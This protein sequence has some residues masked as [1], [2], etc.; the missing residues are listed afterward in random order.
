MKKLVLLSLF[1][2]LLAALSSM[3]ISSSEA[4]SIAANWVNQ[5][6][7]S[8]T[9]AGIEAVNNPEQ[10]DVTDWYVI[11]FTQG[12]FILI[13][14]DDRIQPVLGYNTTGSFRMVG[15]PD[16]LVW[17]TKSYHEQIAVIKAS[18]NAVSHPGWQLVRNG[19][20][21]DFL[22][23][24]AVSP[25]LQTNWDQGWP[26]NSLCPSASQGPGGHVYA[27]CG[28]TTMGQIMKYW[29]YPAH[30]VGSHTYTHPTYG[31]L[32]ANFGTATYNYS[33]MP[34]QLNWSAN[35][36]IST[37][38]YH[39]GIALDMDYGVDGSGA[40]VSDVRPAFVNYFSF[41]T[42][43]QTVYKSGYPA[44]AWDTLLKS[45]LDNS[46]PIFYFGTD[47]N[48]GVGHA[49]VCDGYQ[50]TNYFH[51]NW[52]WSGSDN[53][54]FYFSDLNPGSYHFNAQ[55]GAV[56]GLRPTAPVTAPTN[57]TSLV[58]PGDN[59]YLEWQSPLTRALLGF[60]VYRNGLVYDSITD[61]ANTYYFDINL[62]PGTYQYYIVANFSQ[63]D[64]QPSNTTIATIYPQAIINYQ[65][66][67]ETYNNFT[68]SLSPWF[69]Y[70]LDLSPTVQLENINYPT[71]GEAQ[72]FI[73]FNP[74][75]TTPPTTNFTAQSGQKVLA[76][77]GAVTAPNNDWIVSP[78]W[79]TAS[80]GRMKFWA[81]SAYPD[82]YLELI[83]V[84]IN[85]DSPNPSGMTIVSGQTPIS[86]PGTWTEYDF[87][88]TN[89]LYSNVFVGIQCVSNNGKMLLLDRLQLWSSYVDNE[90]II[91]V[92]SPG[93]VLTANPN[94]F[95][96][97][98]SV[99]WQ[100]KEA[101][102]VKVKV[103]D[104]KGQLVRTLLE[105][106]MPKGKNSFEWN[107]KDNKGNRVANG[108]YFL[109]LKDDAGHSA[110]SKLVK[111]N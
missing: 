71:E 20:F 80:V 94:P 5:I 6:S 41:E 108:M 62:T 57:L 100:Q 14:A 70:D 96:S 49:F 19:Y 81:K 24:R 52:G 54:Y 35:T 107:G 90:D 30:G 25:L 109:N 110:T 7:N 61:P 67:F 1:C 37:L 2:L 56:I 69:T 92:S 79:N 43:A 86:V 46:R 106:Q 48:I 75:A 44:T 26:Y 32:S 65:D 74:A 93:I 8:N 36:A 88:F 16:N 84:G 87:T 85:P 68:T 11:N 83:K 95:S 10:I 38:L 22:P 104:I 76:C 105:G 101:S 47:T 103:Y 111:I 28:A 59:I 15:M 82:T 53:G 23:D 98:T 45:E 89:N 33:S 64:S 63:G 27:G 3:Q 21:N 9:V 13:S 78:K 51:I 97:N 66:S 34:N 42:T 72:S 55:Q 39:C 4:L 17:F 102:T 40:S 73:V 31:T 91:D 77:F 99:N 29:Q 60:T 18:G 58:D 12:G 50:G